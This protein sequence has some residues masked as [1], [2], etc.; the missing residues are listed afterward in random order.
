MNY[1]RK[2]CELVPTI[3]RVQSGNLDKWCC[4]EHLT[5]SLEDAILHSNGTL[6]A[7]VLQIKVKK[8]DK[9]RQFYAPKILYKL[10]CPELHVSRW[11]FWAE[12]EKKMLDWIGSAWQLTFNMESVSKKVEKLQCFRFVDAPNPNKRVTKP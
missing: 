7:F 4:I 12:M 10:F 2:N 6:M 9:W 8:I 3:P 11:K 5:R 1:F